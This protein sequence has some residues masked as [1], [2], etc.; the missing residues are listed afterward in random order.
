MNGK[1]VGI[2]DVTLPVKIGAVLIAGPCPDC[3]SIKAKMFGCP[4][5][6]EIVVT[7]A[8]CGIER[9]RVEL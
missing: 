4:T 3:G 8:G 6:I 5:S 7:C 1:I 9:A 2:I